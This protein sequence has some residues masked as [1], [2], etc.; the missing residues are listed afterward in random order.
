MKISIAMAAYNGGRYLKDQLDSFVDQ[1][2]QPDEL[3]I[4]DDGSTDDTVAVAETFK[5]VAPFP[6]K[7]LKSAGGLGFAGNFCQALGAATGDLVFLSDQDDVWFPNK[8]RIVEDVARQHPEYLAILNDCILTDADL[9]P[10]GMT[11]M[12]QL[13]SGGMSLD[14]LVMGCCAAVRK[15]LLDLALPVPLGYPAH[16]N[17]LIKIAGGMGRKKVVEAALQFY[18]RH[19]ANSS[20]FI[21]N[22]LRKVRHHDALWAR[23]KARAGAQG[24]PS[25]TQV[26]AENRLLLRGIERAESRSAS[27]YYKEDL[28]K[29][30]KRMVEL[31]HYAEE[32]G[33]VRNK[34]ALLRVYGVSRLWLKGGYRHFSG[35][36][37][38]ASDFVAR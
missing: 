31:V 29:L 22:R 26:L 6:V 36:L 23:I 7:V 35:L 15:D 3:V 18:R 5:G 32:R 19:G 12:Q 9:N 38:A 25:F 37:S 1:E 33:E 14:H 2:R 4:S 28:A 8:L 34:K 11:K 16:D 13:K 24:G 10:V 27:P 17:W 20:P 21:A 30:R